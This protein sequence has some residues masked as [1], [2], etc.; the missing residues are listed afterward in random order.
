[1]VHLMPT[2]SVFYNRANNQGLPP[3]QKIID[4]TNLS[5]PAITGPLSKGE[6]QDY[7]F[8]VRLLD[9]KI[10]LRAARYTTN[11]TDLT[12]S[13]SPTGIAPSVV[14]ARFRAASRSNSCRVSPRYWTQIRGSDS[15][16]SNNLSVSERPWGST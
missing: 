14:G 12:M 13:F 5:A 3:S 10:N 1:M 15:N 11:T 9:G 8:N 7:G 16:P 2:I 6:G 4:I